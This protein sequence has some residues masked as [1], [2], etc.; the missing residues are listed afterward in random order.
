MRKKRLL[1]KIYPSY[2]LLTFISLAAVGWF[3]S[4]ACRHFYHRRTA[5]DL[6][7][8]AR[9]LQ[10]QVSH[11]LS[12]KNY[13]AVDRLCKEIGRAVSTGVS[14]VLPSGKIIGSSHSN[15]MDKGHQTELVQAFSG[16]VGISTEYNS[17]FQKKVMNVAVP[18][19][20][21]NAVSGVIR[22]SIP[23]ETIDDEVKSIQIRILISGLLMAL[24][25]SG[26][27]FIVS[28]NLSRP[29]EEMTRGA[30]R[31]ASGDLTYRLPEFTLQETAGLAS[32]MNQMANQLDERLNLAV[33]QRSET[34][35]VLSSMEEGVI[36]IDREER[37]I[38][39]N[40]AA[41][42][43]F[44][45]TPVNLQGRTIQEVIR[46]KD[47]HRFVEK[48]LLSHKRI[49][50]DIT[51]FQ[52]E[53]RILF[54]HSTPLSNAQDNQIGT[55]IVLND[56][57]RLRRLE[58][59]RRDFVANVTHEIK[60]PLTAIKGFVETLSSGSVDSK[61]EVQR[62][63]G[64]VMKHVD[65]L[66]AIIEDLLS[67]SRI[68]REKELNTITFKSHPVRKVLKM[69]IQTC[70]LKMEQKQIQ[71]DLACEDSIE[72]AMDP[73]LIE[74][75]AVNL[76]DNALN[77]SGDNSTI[78]VSAVS[79]DSEIII[80]VKDHG[81]GIAKEHIPRLFERFYRVDKAR[82]RHLGGTGLGL[83][84]VKHIT[85]IHGGYVAVTSTPGEGSVFKIHLPR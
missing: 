58:N 9:I 7:A 84:I 33:Q 46:N 16:V 12:A 32:A 54:A 56:V 79:Y 82:S 69:A 39:I 55:L 34:E 80:Q 62:F 19:F 71:V 3:T 57:T 25:A 1:W 42:D 59:M 72:A 36:A 76:I 81:V 13:S 21:K 77:Y 53:E 28:R 15:A 11:Y 75:A 45:A 22:T 38:S 78:L 65:R 67:L 27:G 10:Q 48:A 66:A 64:I 49:E 26:I 29:I 30:S 40:R 18:I 35:A 68:E 14:V 51:L 44:N 70:R 74:Q 31:F 60:T 2:L 5:S 52:G 24:L 85:Q 37:V 50:E 61:E 20:Q 17:H 8:R 41:S 23:V 83:A 6:E 43:I 47:V 4:S 73:G 63:L